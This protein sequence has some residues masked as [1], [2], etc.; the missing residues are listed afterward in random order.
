M[1]A[2]RHP[3]PVLCDNLEGWGEEGGGRGFKRKDLHMFRVNKNLKL[4]SQI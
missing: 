2:R 4:Q 1:D 3:V